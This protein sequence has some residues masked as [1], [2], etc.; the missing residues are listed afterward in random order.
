MLHTIS[1]ESVFHGIVLMT[2]SCVS[3]CE[4]LVHAAIVAICLHHPSVLLVAPVSAPLPLTVWG[5]CRLLRNGR[6]VRSSLLQPSRLVDFLGP[7]GDVSIVAP[8]CQPEV[9]AV[10]DARDAHNHMPHCEMR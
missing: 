3:P 6:L 5:A 2:I 8:R 4:T 1:L 10:V 9:F 7:A